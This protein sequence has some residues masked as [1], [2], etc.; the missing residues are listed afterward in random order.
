MISRD[1]RSLR[2]DQE[3][4]TGSCPKEHKN[5][6]SQLFRNATPQ[7]AITVAPARIEQTCKALDIS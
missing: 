1:K 5:L 3:W 4:G 7:E 6:G 2:A